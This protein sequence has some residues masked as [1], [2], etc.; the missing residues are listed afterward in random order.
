MGMPTAVPGPSTHQLLMWV[1]QNSSS[2]CRP[3]TVLP[4][5][6]WETGGSYVKRE[7][8][9]NPHES[10]NGGGLNSLRCI[11]LPG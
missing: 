1:V 2:S 9:S 7:Q 4:S 11:C 10:L 6:H 5:A 3:A 8:D